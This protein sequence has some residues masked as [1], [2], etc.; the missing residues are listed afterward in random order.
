MCTFPE[1]SFGGARRG[2]VVSEWNSRR[3]P[4]GT[5]S[6][7]KSFRRLL[8]HRKNLTSTYRYAASICCGA[9]FPAAVRRGDHFRKKVFRYRFPEVPS[10][11]GPDR[12]FG[13]QKRRSSICALQ[14]LS[15][16]ESN[17]KKWNVFENS[18]FVLSDCFNCVTC[19]SCEVVAFTTRFRNVLFLF[20]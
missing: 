5:S 11:I 18:V 17:G 7:P 20:A 1:D 13:C 12:L 10:F 14:H 6:R 3:C 16:R 15:K 2:V 19:L 8:Q 9:K 4:S